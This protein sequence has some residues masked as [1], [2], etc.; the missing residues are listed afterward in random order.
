MASTTPTDYWNDSCSVAELTYAIERGAVGATTNPTIVGDVLGKEMELWREWI[1]RE[2]AGRPSATE[3]ELAWDLIEA[4]AVKGAELLDPVFEREG[5]LKGRLSI[6]TDP[7]LYRTTS[8][9]VEQALRFAELAP[10]IQVKIP[11]TNAGIEAIE[12]VTAAG[13]NVNATVS[14]TVPQVIAVAEAVERGLARREGDSSSMRPVA[15]MMIGRLDDWMAALA[16]RDGVLLTP[17]VAS[18]AGI[19]CFKRAYTIFR[20]RGYRTRLLAAA[21]R[22]ELHW[23]ELVGGDVVLTIPHKW[24]VLFN[25]SGT[26][27]RSR[28]DE[29][30]PAEAL[31]ELV[32][33]LPDFRRAFEPDGLP[34]AEF[35]SYGATVRTLRAFISSY[36]DLVAVVRDFM[37][38]SPD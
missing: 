30:A 10:N 24:Q 1:E 26:P 20:E 38:P 34:V 9:I 3:D 18:W 27:V 4:M 14:F 12:E 25:E 35:D 6:Q 15:T 13:V 31:E 2:V 17:G 8:A 5:G 36:H 22:N 19:G 23:T 37:L 11:A 32:A 16:E 29:P 21:Y 7:R 28:I 33:K